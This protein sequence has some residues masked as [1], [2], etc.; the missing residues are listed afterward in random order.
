MRMQSR[1]GLRSGNGYLSE[2]PTRLLLEE[3]KYQGARLARAEVEVVRE[4]FEEEASKLARGAT[5]VGTGGALLY[6]SVLSLA[7]VGISL[8]ALVVPLWA[9]AL[10]VAGVYALVGWGVATAG[11][12]RVRAVRVES[13]LNEFKEDW[14]WFRQTTQDM[15]VQRRVNA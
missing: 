3:L 14:E 2:V 15:R 8:L 13:S 5:M 12:A 7:V 11:R 1:P 6:A 4:E 10:I 9:A